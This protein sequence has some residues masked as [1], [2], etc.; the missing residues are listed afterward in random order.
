VSDGVSRLPKGRGGGGATAL[1]MIKDNRHNA[2]SVCFV[3][4]VLGMTVAAVSYRAV[5]LLA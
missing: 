5:K 1:Y 3:S 2:V 4:E